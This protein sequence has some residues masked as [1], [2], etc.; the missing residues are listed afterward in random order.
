M[1]CLRNW[2]AVVGMMLCA[3]VLSWAISRNLATRSVERPRAVSDSLDGAAY[4]KPEPWG[5][6]PIEVRPTDLDS[7][8]HV[9]NA[10][11]LEYCQ[12]ARWQFLDGR[13]L[14][15]AALASRGVVV[16]VRHIDI[17]Y[18]AECGYGDAITVSTVVDEIGNTS[19][20]LRHDVFKGGSRLAARCVVVMVALSTADDRKPTP[21]PDAVRAA[22]AK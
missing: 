6:Q 7:K 22:L 17:D 14:D 11:Y 18:E 1:K 3:G 21:L 4:Y 12:H 19:F 15:T 9:N 8:G 5:A 2:P 20:K 13:G 10:R 16:V